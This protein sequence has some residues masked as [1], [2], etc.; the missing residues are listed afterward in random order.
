MEEAAR[1]DLHHEIFPISSGD[2]PFIS[3]TSEI[4]PAS[5]VRKALKCQTRSPCVVTLQDRSIWKQASVTLELVQYHGHFDGDALRVIL[6]RA[7]HR[8]VEFR[9]IWVSKVAFNLEASSTFTALA[10][11]AVKQNHRGVLIFLPS[12]CIYDPK[13]EAQE[14]VPLCLKRL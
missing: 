13:T 7:N 3:D 6:A 11:V 4:L 2:L 5:P 14:P 12:F 9:A 8:H 10:T 1:R